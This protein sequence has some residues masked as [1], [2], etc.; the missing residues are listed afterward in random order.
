VLKGLYVAVRYQFYP[1]HNRCYIV[2]LWRPPRNP[3]GARAMSSI[4]NYLHRS[5]PHRPRRFAIATRPLLGPRDW[6]AH[7]SAVFVIWSID[8]NP[9]VA[10]NMGEKRT[11][12][13][14]SGFDECLGD[15]ALS[16]HL[17]LIVV[18]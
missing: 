8:A 1:D 6:I 5:S 7:D 18:V 14:L 12:R 11:S 10:P 3:S 9:G 17:M 4:E 2:D 15:H 13:S 16:E